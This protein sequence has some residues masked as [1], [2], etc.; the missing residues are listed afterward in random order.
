MSVGRWVAVAMAFAIPTVLISAPAVSAESVLAW[1]QNLD[2]ECDVP[3]PNAGFVAVS[4]GSHHSLGLKAD[5][6]MAAW[7]SNGYGQCN[8]PAPNADFVAI[9][10]GGMH[11]LGLKS[12]SSIVAWGYNA[13]GE[14]NV[15]SPNAGFIAVAAGSDVSLG[16][17]ADGSIVAWGPDW[18]GMCDVPAPNTDFVGMS[19]GLVHVVGLKAD[20]STVMWGCN[21]QGQLELPEPPSPFQA[22]S[23]GGNHKLG[24]CAADLP[25]GACCSIANACRV[26]VQANCFSPSSWEGEETTCDPNPCSGVVMGA[27]CHWS[28]CTIEAPAECTADGGIYRG[29]GVL[30]EPLPCENEDVSTEGDGVLSEMRSLPTPSGGAVRVEFRQSEPGEA[31]LQIYRVDGALVRSVRAGLLGAGHHAL[32]WDGK[33]EDGRLVPPGVYLARVAIGRVVHT[34]RVVLSR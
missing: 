23:A 13:Y 34:G 1:G 11:S 17:K 6:T 30:C 7:G 18:C 24:L 28:I 8:V 22:V 33:G 2:G 14:C 10:A 29:D 15:P 32:A 31:V 25:T 21:D 27:C 16:L 19:A 4:A 12:D 26:T 3:A 20:G 5:G 9:A